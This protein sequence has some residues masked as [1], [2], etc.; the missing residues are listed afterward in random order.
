M[1]RRPLVHSG[2]QP[3]TQAIVSIWCSAV[4]A[5]SEVCD[6]L[7][8]PRREGQLSRECEERSNQCVECARACAGMRA[9][10]RVPGW[11]GVIP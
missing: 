4:R 10:V 11:G 9:R 2:T 8:Q 6:A 7:R 5:R 1:D 3:I